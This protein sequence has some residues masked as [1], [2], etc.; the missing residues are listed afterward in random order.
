[1]KSGWLNVSGTPIRLALPVFLLAAAGESSA[2]TPVGEVP[3][4][5]LASRWATGLAGA[6]MPFEFGPPFDK[7]S[8]EPLR[9]VPLLVRRPEEARPAF[10]GALARAPGRRASLEGLGKAARAAGDGETANRVSPRRQ[11]IR[12]GGDGKAGTR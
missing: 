7:P 3:T 1:M 10:E 4:R 9:E 5:R 12:R 6:A 2:R 11:E 8:H